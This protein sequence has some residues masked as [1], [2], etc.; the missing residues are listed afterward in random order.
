MFTSLL[1]AGASCDMLFWLVCSKRLLQFVLTCCGCFVDMSDMW[2]QRVA[3][4]Q[5]RSCCKKTR[6]TSA[7][8]RHRLGQ[9]CFSKWPIC[10]LKPQYIVASCGFIEQLDPKMTRKYPEGLRHRKMWRPHS[11]GFSGT[12][13]LRHPSGTHRINLNRLQRSWTWKS[14]RVSPWPRC[15]CPWRSWK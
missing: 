7:P 3:A 8:W 1:V 11:A 12:P 6:M 5:F 9:T 14:S 13:C 2:H 15:S 10:P 4:L